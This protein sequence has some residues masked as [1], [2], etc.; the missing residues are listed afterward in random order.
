MREDIDVADPLCSQI[1]EILPKTKD[2]YYKLILAVGPARSGKT[3]AL[4]EL[5][6][7]RRW[8]RL[9]VNLSLSEKLLELFH[10]Q[11]AV[12]VAGIL[13]DTLRSSDSDIV[14]L[15]NLELLFA[16]ELAQD[17]L[18]LLQALSRN[19]TIIAA[20]PGSF[21]GASLT[22]AE[23]GHPEVR[24]YLSPEAVIV[25]V[26]PDGHVDGRVVSLP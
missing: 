23:T 4:A 13:D 19:R 24:R 22:Y 21:D 20:W 6:R 10:R 5:A 17:P 25:T 18:R 7:K 15:D 11:R 3:S 1:E 2:A 9:N 12:R 16:P 8:P 26:H 14:L